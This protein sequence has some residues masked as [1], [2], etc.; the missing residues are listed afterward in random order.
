[1]TVGN[2]KIY[3]DL[4]V[5]VYALLIWQQHKILWTYVNLRT[6]IVLFICKAAFHGIHLFSLFVLAQ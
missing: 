4:D 6:I 1:M 5:C 3:K 2:F